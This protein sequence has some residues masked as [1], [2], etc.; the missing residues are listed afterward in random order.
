MTAAL[1]AGA[2]LLTV[3]ALVSAAT[4]LALTRRPGTALPVL[5]DSLLAP[6]LLR[7]AAHPSLVQLGGTALLV[8]VKRLAMAGLRTASGARQVTAGP[9]ATAPRPT[10]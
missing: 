4:T 1:S 8:V 7:L 5:L 3:A 10:R 6:S 2:L 9:A